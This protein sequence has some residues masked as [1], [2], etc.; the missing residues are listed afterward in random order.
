LSFEN[1]FIL[2]KTKKQTIHLPPTAE[3]LEEGVFS[4]KPIK[5]VLLKESLHLGNKIERCQMKKGL[6]DP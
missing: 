4:P 3:A 5:W 2:K 6:P 1:I